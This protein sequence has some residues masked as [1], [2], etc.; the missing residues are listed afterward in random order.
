MKARTMERTLVTGGTG[1]IGSHLVDVL[2]TQEAHVSVLDNLT[3]GTLENIKRWRSNTN[4]TF[5]KGDLLSKSDLA[6]IE[7]TRFET[8]FHLAANPE[9]LLTECGVEEVPE[10]AD[11]N[12]IQA[13]I[14]KRPKD[15]KRI[16]N[17]LIEV[18]E[19]VVIYVPRFKLVYRNTITGKEKA[20]E[21]DGVTGKRIY[22]HTSAQKAQ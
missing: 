19:R 8:I 16:V 18:N 6:N 20:I 10:D 21:F 4:L 3:V 14:L 11:L 1:F 17:E 15:I 2:M 5:I 9:K 12:I 13:R 22:T 7:E